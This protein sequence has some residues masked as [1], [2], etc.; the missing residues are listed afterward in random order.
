MLFS[1]LDR[2]IFSQT[3]MG[4]L[5]AA[6]GVCLSIILVDI[7]EQLRNLSGLAHATLTTALKFTLMRTPGILELALP[8]AVLVGSI[9]TFMRLARSS[10]IVALRASGVSTWRF[11]SPVAV[12]AALLGLFAIGIL[13][14]AA[15]R[16][17][18]AYETQLQAISMVSATRTGV[19]PNSMLWLRDRS[20]QNYYTVAAS[21]GS[22]GKYEKV[23]FF[24]FRQTDGSFLA[25]YDAQTGYRTHQG[26]TLKSGIETSIGKPS[27]FFLERFFPIMAEPIDENRTHE[28]AIRAIPVWDLPGTARN[29]EAGGGSAQRYWLHFHRKLALPLA[30][31][32]MAMIAAV[33][34]LNSERFGQ[35]A[36][37]AAAAIAA[38]L[39]VYFVNDISG[40]LATAGY[41][42]SW[43]AAWC[44]PFAALFIA[45]ATISFREDG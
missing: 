42:S 3:L 33:L 31:V 16:L 11:L 14:P 35:R 5:V 28:A 34:S 12:L 13:S 45:L 1:R 7:V 23:T 25:R 15:A 41:A 19:G 40:A 18:L 22:D 43:I 36:I 37:M 38:G 32:S 17:N 20:E 8:F 24:V 21:S 4:I 10:Q 29:A 39:V 2:Y 6:G 27:Q 30:L 44:P 9:V 26:W